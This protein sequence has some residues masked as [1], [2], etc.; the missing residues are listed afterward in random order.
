MTITG[1][2]LK[3][4]PQK[5]IVYITIQSSACHT[6]LA[7]RKHNKSLWSQNMVSDPMKL[8]PTD[9]QVYCRLCQNYLKNYY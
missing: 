5:A 6:Y 4:L 9:R 3:E 2:I 7:N 8:H 1:K